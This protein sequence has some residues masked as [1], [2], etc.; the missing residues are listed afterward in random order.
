MATYKEIKGVTL[1]TRDED[2]VQNVGTWSSDANMN[3]ARISSTGTGSSS[4]GYIIAGGYYL[5]PSVDRSVTESYNGT[6]WTEVADCPQDLTYGNGL[7]SYTSSLLC[8]Y[9][10]P[11]PAPGGYGP[12]TATHQW[13]G[14]SWS[15]KNSMNTFRQNAGTGGTT[16]AG[17]VFGGSGPPA[18]ANTETWDGT[19][20]T[21]VGDLNTAKTDIGGGVGTSTAALSASGAP[22]TTEQWDGSSWTEVSDLNTSRQNSGKVGLYTSALCV[23]GQN[24]ST[25]LANVESWD[26]TSWTEVSDVSAARGYIGGATISGGNATGIVAGGAGPGSPGLLSSTEI[27]TAP[28]VFSQIIEGQ[29]YF[30][31]TTNTFKETI[32]DLPAGTW[33]SQT[34]INTA[35]G[36]GAG[37]GT[38]DSALIYGGFTNPPSVTYAQTEEWNGSTWTEKGDL[39]VPFYYVDAGGLGT[40]TA[41]LAHG[42]EGPSGGTGGETF[43]GS[44]WSEISNSNSNHIKAGGAGSSTAGLAIASYPPTSPN[45]Q[46]EE[47]NGSAWTEI[48]DVNEGRGDG[49]GSGTSTSA[50]WCGG[51]APG[52]SAKTEVWDGTSW[53]ESGDLNTARYAHRGSGA[54]QNDG[55]V[56]GG[57]VPSGS[58]EAAKTE[59]WNGSTWTEIND[60][61]T[62][63]QNIQ[64]SGG[65]ASSAATALASGGYNAGTNAVEEFTAPLANKTITAS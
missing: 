46:V 2:P 49:A 37:C 10:Q 63:R 22:A 56:Y 9:S 3:T 38:K 55:L 32:T 34:N 59:L 14:S 17:I 15:T 6:A 43:N 27:W 47:W 62:G 7:G 53:T 18:N 28:S 8:S 57:P 41:A 52:N 40:V 51:E 20:W 5:P 61:G 60:L 42:G 1:Q 4:E 19:N 12:T 11:G 35:R 33:S 44:S 30:N 31:S 64:S 16:T 25:Y 65:N 48:A 54:N 24:P 21:E 26:G 23:S 13:N 50:W 36:L 45:E 58:A 39:N 29:L